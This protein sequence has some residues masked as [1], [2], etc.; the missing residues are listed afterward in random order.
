[1]RIIKRCRATTYCIINQSPMYR[2]GGNEIKCSVC[3]HIEKFQEP[4]RK[5]T[6]E[7]NQKLIDRISGRCMNSIDEID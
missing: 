1:M 5:F 7:E 2:N 3:D 4:P 6:P